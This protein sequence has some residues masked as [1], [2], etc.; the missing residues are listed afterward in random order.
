MW[1]CE[2]DLFVGEELHRLAKGCGLKVW[3]RG[4]AISSEAYRH[5]SDVDDDELFLLCF[6]CREQRD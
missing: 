4:R 6:R 2:Q 3:F 5:R 1:P